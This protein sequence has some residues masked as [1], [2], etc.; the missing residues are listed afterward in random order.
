MKINA[1]D[2]EAKAYD[3]AAIEAW[4]QVADA[5]A[6]LLK[7][8]AAH[9]D[10]QAV[11]DRKA[12]DQM[13]EQLE[14]LLSQARE[15][16]GEDFEIVDRPLEVGEARELSRFTL[17]RRAPMLSANAAAWIRCRMATGQNPRNF[18]ELLGHGGT[19]SRLVP[20]EDQ[21]DGVPPVF[22]RLAELAAEAELNDLEPEGSKPGDSDELYDADALDALEDADLISTMG[23]SK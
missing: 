2:L 10:A 12:R 16:T 6:D 15:L 19:G 13:D 7:A 21:V 8:N 11:K 14:S 3:N 5:R 20:F 22:A 17:T 23:I 1:A 9:Y 18:H 4:M